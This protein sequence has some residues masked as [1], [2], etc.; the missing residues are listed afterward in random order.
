MGTIEIPTTENLP[1][2]TKIF[3]YPTDNIPDNRLFK[4]LNLIEIS[5]NLSKT[6]LFFLYR[7]YVVSRKKRFKKRY[8]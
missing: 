8:Y 1:E 5:F 6:M 4:T 7:R 3:E 2:T